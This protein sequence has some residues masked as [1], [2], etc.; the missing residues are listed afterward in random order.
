MQVLRE[1]RPGT[2]C[3]DPRDGRSVPKGNWRLDAALIDPTTGEVISEDVTPFV[4]Q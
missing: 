2:P 1:D 4:V 3:L